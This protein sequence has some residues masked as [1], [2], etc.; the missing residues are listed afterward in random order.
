[1]V[2]NINF[3]FRS[4]RINDADDA[5]NTFSGPLSTVPAYMPPF[6]RGQS[7]VYLL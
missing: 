6:T 5:Q 7:D 2:E 4:Y 3:S 1:M